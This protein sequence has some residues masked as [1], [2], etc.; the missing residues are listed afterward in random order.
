[1]TEQ[2]MMETALYAAVVKEPRKDAPR[3][4]L[5]AWL[6]ER[7]PDRARYVQLAIEESRIHRLRLWGQLP[8]TSELVAGRDRLGA[9]ARKRLG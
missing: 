7:W 4:A 1:M 2:E 3:L 9:E 8:W 6:A 5:A